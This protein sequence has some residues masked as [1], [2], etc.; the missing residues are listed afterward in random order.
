MT[1][2]I[3]VPEGRS[4]VPEDQLDAVTETMSDVVASRVQQFRKRRGWSGRRLAEACAA[5]GNPQI[6]ESVVANIESGRRDEHGRRRRD[7]TVDEL[8]AFAR[9]L[10]VSVALLLWSSTTQ[11]HPPFG[12]PQ[13]LLA[14]RSPAEQRDFLR[15]VESLLVKV[16]DELE[17]LEQDGGGG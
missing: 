6:T 7:V 11:A 14:L 8:V 15:E 2:G 12:P 1:E 4:P 9:A 16:R 10:D 13:T 5:T 3:Q 17:V